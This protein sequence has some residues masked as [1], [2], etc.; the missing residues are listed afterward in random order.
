MNLDHC[1]AIIFDFD[2]VIGKTM[3]D[4]F[5][6]WEAAFQEINISI[7][8]NEYYELEGLKAIDVAQYFLKLNNHSKSA[9]EIVTFKESYYEKNNRFS[10][11]PGVVELLQEFKKTKKLALVTGANRSRLDFTR[12]KYSSP[13]DVFSFFDV[14]VSATDVKAGKPHPEP[15][16]KA[17]DFLQLPADKCLVI[18]NAPLGITSA[19][20]AGIKC[21]G[22]TSTLKKEKLTEA[23]YIYSS[24][25]D[26]AQSLGLTT[27]NRN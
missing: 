20:K 11:Y 13:V 8:E 9:A 6:A 17:L 18:E 5:L 21:V 3:H 2:G 23:D 19:K 26:L 4:N 14:I 1:Q 27:I 15:Y 7:N 16:L 12:S 25:S 24:I 22:I 10:F